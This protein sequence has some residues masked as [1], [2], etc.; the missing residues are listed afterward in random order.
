MCLDTVQDKVTTR[1]RVGYKVFERREDGILFSKFQYGPVRPVGVEIVDDSNDTLSTYS[2]VLYP[3][4]FHI[5]L[6][7]QAVSVW[8]FHS[9]RT[10]VIRKVKFSHLVAEG[11][12]ELQCGK[13]KSVVARR[14]TILPDEVK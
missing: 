1:Q 6:T 13:Y 4:G 9:P 7:K 2:G 3:T 14:M 11:T 12:Q 5:F 10:T 8:R